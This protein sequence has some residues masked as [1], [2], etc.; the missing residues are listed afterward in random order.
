[1]NHNFTNQEILE[2]YEIFARLISEKKNEMFWNRYHERN[3]ENAKERIKLDIE[4]EKLYDEFLKLVKYS[5]KMGNMYVTVNIND[6]LDEMIKFLNINKEDIKIKIYPIGKINQEDNHIPNASY[7]LRMK[8]GE[9]ELNLLDIKLNSLVQNEE[10]PTDKITIVYGGGHCF[11]KWETP[12]EINKELNLNYSNIEL[13]IQMAS[14]K[15]Y[16]DKHHGIESE[17]SLAFSNSVLNI[18][19]QENKDIKK[20][21]K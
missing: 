8:L 20:L 15:Y 19:K 13:G 4:Y 16:M 9:N 21:T 6:V 14:L 5:Q 1:M 3:A 2:G 17:E 7:N 18:I 12:E 10:A 11:G